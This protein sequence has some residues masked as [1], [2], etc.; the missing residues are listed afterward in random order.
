[1]LVKDNLQVCS[2]SM[3]FTYY[4]KHILYL[5]VFRLSFGWKIVQIFYSILRWYQ[6]VRRFFLSYQ[7]IIQVLYS[8]KK[9]LWQY[10][11]NLISIPW[12]WMMAIFK[13]HSIF[14][15]CQHWINRFIQ[16][17]I[18]HLQHTLQNLTNVLYWTLFSWQCA[19]VEP[20]CIALVSVTICLV[21]Y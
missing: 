8:Y 9:V 18:N 10:Y 17:W 5:M 13:Y 16:N 7:E 2:D 1:M 6:L 14:N 11:G 3:Y 15:I 21:A 20:N 19:T 12:Y 4:M